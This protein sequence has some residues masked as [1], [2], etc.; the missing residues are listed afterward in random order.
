MRRRPGLSGTSR[1]SALEVPAPAAWRVVASGLD[2]PQWYVD[3][4]PFVVRGAIDRALGGSGRR[5]RPPGTSQLATGDRAGF[6]EV[7]DA[8]PVALRLVLRAAVRAPGEVRLTTTVQPR[9]EAAC[10]ITQRVAFAPDGLV[11]HAYRVA[12]L[13]AREAVLELAHRRLL[14]D[15]RAG[16]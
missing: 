8:D 3:A 14:A 12:D 10:R 2:G 7:E 6:W 1:I 16:A 13:P 4:A 11:G 15:V 9:G 5:W